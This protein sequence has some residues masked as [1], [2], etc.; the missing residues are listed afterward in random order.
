MVAKRAGYS[1]AELEGLSA[2]K[3]STLIDYL[4]RNNWTRP[5]VAQ[6]EAILGGELLEQENIL[7][8]AVII[9]R[10]P[11]SEELDEFTKDM[12]PAQ[13]YAVEEAM[14]CLRYAVNK[15]REALIEQGRALAMLKAA[16]RYGQWSK[17]L[18]VL[19]VSRATAHRQIQLALAHDSTPAK[20]RRLLESRGVRF[21]PTMTARQVEIAQKASEVAKNAKAEAAQL[22][23]GETTDIESGDF[24]DLVLESQRQDRVEAV[25]EEKVSA[26]L[27]TQLGPRLLPTQSLQSVGR[28]E[29]L[30]SDSISVA[31]VAG[32]I[33]NFVVDELRTCPTE[34]R[35][36]V[37][38][39]AVHYVEMETGVRV[40]EVESKVASYGH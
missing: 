17:L 3:A 24:G 27:A 13:G 9:A 33:A 29:S 21:C 10:I 7:E 18:N 5:N 12:P 2:S 23:H 31:I 35:N 40:E 14:D 1:G 26:F 32:R 37:W 28:P 20:L 22:F 16:L 25:V 15:G 39:S 19:G 36:E 38:K 11:T 4:S 8:P 34:M 30:A 6:Q